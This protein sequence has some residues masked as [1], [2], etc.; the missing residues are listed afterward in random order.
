MAK[1]YHCVTR[2]IKPVFFRGLTKVKPKPLLL[3]LLHQSY[4]KARIIIITS[5]LV[6]S[7]SPAVYRRLLNINKRNNM[8]DVHS[9]GVKPYEKCTSVNELS[10]ADRFKLCCDVAMDVLRVMFYSLFVFAEKLLELFSSPMPK[11]IAGHIALVTGG[12]NGLGK[13]VAR[14]L[15][16]IGCHIVIADVDIQNAKETAEDIREF[17]V[18]SLAFKV[19]TNCLLKSIAVPLCEFFNCFEYCD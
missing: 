4:I 12:G 2:S 16:A 14:K 15:A 3:L 1:T 6:D 13:E 18:K 9:A 11:N 19:S 8:E 5:Y 10:T 7:S 17:N